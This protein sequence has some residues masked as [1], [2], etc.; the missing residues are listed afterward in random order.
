MQKNNNYKMYNTPISLNS[1]RRNNPLSQINRPRVVNNNGQA[2]NGFNAAANNRQF[3]QRH[4][5][6]GGTG[7][8]NAKQHSCEICGYTSTLT[9]VTKHKR[10]HTGEKPYS[11]P[12][13][14]KCFS[15]NS[16]MLRHYRKHKPH[17]HE[18]LQKRK[19]EEAAAAAAST[20]KN[21]TA[22]VVA[23][24]Q[25]TDVTEAVPK[26][27]V[28]NNVTGPNSIPAS[29]MKLPFSAQVESSVNFARPL[30]LV[31]SANSAS[32]SLPAA[33]ATAVITTSAVS[34]SPVTSPAV[35][36]ASPGSSASQNADLPV[37]K[38]QAAS[39]CQPVTK[40]EVN[41]EEEECKPPMDLSE[42]SPSSNDGSSVEEKQSEAA[43]VA[44]RPNTT[45]AI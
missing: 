40:M 2:A 29:A 1:R 30:V 19:E 42:K 17:E 23:V 24:P 13:C 18:A 39:P 3:Y 26:F 15:L 37:V 16:N 35:S 14:K 38:Q 5:G 8:R 45:N 44:E 12:I 4:N 31:Q 6:R 11:C 22:P 27:K 36:I 41:E 32:N 34:N 33:I 10:T 28:T 9:D 20:A 43:Q 21:G 7:R 25:I